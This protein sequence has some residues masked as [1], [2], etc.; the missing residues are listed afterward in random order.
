M[1]WRVH[2]VLL[3]VTKLT[4]RVAIE[5]RAA[6]IAQRLTDVLQLPDV[7][8]SELGAWMMQILSKDEMIGWLMHASSTVFVTNIASSPRKDARLAGWLGREIFYLRLDDENL[9]QRTRAERRAAAEW[10]RGLS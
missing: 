6:D 2:L 9:Q 4:R 3:A 7:D 1:P 5:L 10:R 8:S